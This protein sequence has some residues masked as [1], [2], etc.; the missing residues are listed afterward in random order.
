MVGEPIYHKAPDIR[1]PADDPKMRGPSPESGLLFK[2][3]IALILLK[4]GKMMPDAGDQNN[5][6]DQVT[7]PLR[8]VYV[9]NSS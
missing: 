5:W 8:N 6:I 4:R 9:F 7:Y 3:K 2:V 1:F